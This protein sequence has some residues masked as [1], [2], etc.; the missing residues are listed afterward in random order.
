[1]QRTRRRK[2]TDHISTQA[3]SKWSLQTFANVTKEDENLSD[4]TMHACWRS[5]PC[6]NGVT[7]KLVTSDTFL[8]HNNLFMN[9]TQVFG[10]DQR[11]NSSRPQLLDQSRLGAARLALTPLDN[12]LYPQQTGQ[13]EA[14]INIDWSDPCHC[15]DANIEPWILITL[16]I[17]Y[18]L[19][20]FD[21]DNLDILQSEQVCH[22]SGGS[23]KLKMW[24]CNFSEIYYQ[25]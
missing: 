10:F 16:E 12:W 24:G 5:W 15:R 6:R 11:S 1:M 21:A 23:R 2:Q 19:D 8:I 4:D 9:N 14:V 18:T 25:L 3:V 20:T 17:N 13:G 7:F 22:D